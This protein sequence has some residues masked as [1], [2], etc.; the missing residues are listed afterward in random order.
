MASL[1]RLV[2][3]AVCLLVT[4]HAMAG[5]FNATLY[6]NGTGGTNN[7]WNCS[8][9]SYR[10]GDDIYCYALTPVITNYNSRTQT[11]TFTYH[12]GDQTGTLSFEGTNVEIYMRT[13]GNSYE[14]RGIM[15]GGGPPEQRVITVTASFY[16]DGEAPGS[17][18]GGLH[19]SGGDTPAQ[20]GLAALLKV[21]A[22]GAVGAVRSG[23]SAADAIAAV[24]G[25]LF[26]TQ[27]SGIGGVYGQSLGKTLGN[28]FGDYLT[29]F[30]EI[31]GL[32]SSA[33]PQQ[34]NILL[35]LYK[36]TTAEKPA[37]FDQN[38]ADDRAVIEA[39]A[40][41]DPAAAADQYPTFDR[42]GGFGEVS[43]ELVPS[44]A[45]SSIYRFAVNV[46]AFAGLHPISV[47]HTIDL[48]DYRNGPALLVNPIIVAMASAL[49]GFYA[50]QE[51]RRQ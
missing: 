43:Q 1:P 37:D 12:H 16:N 17:L 22:S 10:S 2:L 26:V 19:G 42:L 18:G 47:V 24:V 23:T 34:Y 4:P 3:A 25:T 9:F 15:E 41:V 33:I 38:Y 50:L 51:L 46:P 8:G 35:N 5:S 48:T 13:R 30:Y 14:G 36:L 40:A 45:Q 49:M 6:N 29:Y 11:S 32:E 39:A 20:D 7:F 31:F 44:Y 21:S 27:E 28:M